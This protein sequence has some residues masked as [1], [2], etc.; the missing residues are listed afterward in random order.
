MA[1]KIGMFARMRFKREALSHGLNDNEITALISLAE[2]YQLPLPERLLNDVDFLLEQA[3]RLHGVTQRRTQ[4]SD[5]ADGR[6]HHVFAALRKLQTARNRTQAIIRST[7][8]LGVGMMTRVKI[9]KKKIYQSLITTNSDSGFG[10]KVP[11]DHLGNQ[12][13]LRKGSKLY[14]QAVGDEGNL[15]QFATTVTGYNTIR[16]VAAMFLSH[17]SQIKTVSKRLAPRRFYDKPAYYYPIVVETHPEDPEKK[18]ARVIEERRNIGTVEDISAGG[19]CLRCRAPLP[20]DSLLKA[21]FDT[22]NGDH[23]QVF[24]KVVGIQPNRTG[25][26]RMHVQFTRLSR[27]HLNTIDAFVLGFGERRHNRAG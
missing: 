13:R 10:I 16:G 3:E 5:A 14:L 18:R 15:Y 20:K 2:R 4:S 7:R 22:P 26:Q 6:L 12:I 25:G 8:E 1:K 9:D 24:G 11:R 27:K 19:C 21:E 17:T 23:I